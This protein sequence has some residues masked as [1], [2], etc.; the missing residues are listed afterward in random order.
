M[1]YGVEGMEETQR[2]PFFEIPI[3]YNKRYL[4]DE[5]LWIFCERF[6]NC[7][8]LSHGTRYDHP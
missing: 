2:V 1:V 5:W 7:Q 6:G 3:G 8:Y 4:V